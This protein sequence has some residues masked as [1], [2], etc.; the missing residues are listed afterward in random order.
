VFDDKNQCCDRDKAGSSP[1]EQG[2]EIIEEGA[3][4]EIRKL[5][6]QLTSEFQ[7]DR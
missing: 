7:I 2:Q 3:S 5:P 6:R 4:H 1:L